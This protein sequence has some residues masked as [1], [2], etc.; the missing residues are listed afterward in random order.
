MRRLSALLLACAVLYGCSR[1]GGTATFT[2]EKYGY[3]VAYPAEWKVNAGSMAPP[4]P[5][6]TSFGGRGVAVQIVV[7]DSP[8]NVAEQ[9]S[10]RREG[11]GEAVVTVAG[12]N[13]VLITRPP[14]DTRNGVWR[15][16]YFSHAGRSFE[17]TLQ[18]TDKNQVQ[19][20]QK[21][22]DDIVRSFRWSD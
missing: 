11:W 10:L 6:G 14:M 17:I 15:R 2:N 5:A 21:V 12:E 18:V 9:Q 16:L 20:G 3:T 8:P 7:W 19:H 13:A 4:A 1:S 22:F